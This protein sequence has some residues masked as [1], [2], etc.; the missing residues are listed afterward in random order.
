MDLLPDAEVRH[1][2]GSSLPGAL[3]LGDL[4]LHVRVRPERFAAAV[5]ALLT[6]YEVFRRDH[7]TDAFATFTDPRATDPPIGVALTAV[8]TEHDLRFVRAWERLGADPALLDEYN[9]LKRRY[10]RDP[11]R[12]EAE[13]SAFFTRL[14]RP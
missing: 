6:L 11:A 5:E 10:V 2:G 3:T 8:G 7:W 14:S 4:D 9:A 13:K 12:Y 1:T